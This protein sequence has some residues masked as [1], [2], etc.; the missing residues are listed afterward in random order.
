MV[1]VNAE[2]EPLKQISINPTGKNR[3]SSTY[4]TRENRKSSQSQTQETKCNSNR[5]VLGVLLE[6]VVDLGQLAV[7]RHFGRRDWFAGVAGNRQLERGLIV[8]V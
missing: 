3:L 6:D 7:S 5:R 8:C 4:H 1:E 2:E